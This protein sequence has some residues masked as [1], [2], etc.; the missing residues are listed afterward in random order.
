VQVLLGE[1]RER[2][3]RGGKGRE[4]GKG[5]RGRERG[6]EGESARGRERAEGRRAGKDP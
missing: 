3:E 1:E 6:R 5:R 4:R 2:E